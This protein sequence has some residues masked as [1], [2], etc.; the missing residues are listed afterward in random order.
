MVNCSYSAYN[1]SCLRFQP[2]RRSAEMAKRP[3]SAMGEM[4]DIVRTF[5][6]ALVVNS[7]FY[8]NEWIVA[9]Q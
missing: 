7:S 6:L 3:H 8:I 5:A 1:S 2:S 9:L 4:V